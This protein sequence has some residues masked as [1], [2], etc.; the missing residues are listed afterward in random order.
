M[1]LTDYDP[2]GPDPMME[3]LRTARTEVVKA[4]FDIPVVERPNWVNQESDRV[5]SEQGYTLEAL[6]SRPNF[7]R[8][9]RT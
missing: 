7:S 2:I 5:L 6:P 4:L 1:N 3:E 8:I 9:V